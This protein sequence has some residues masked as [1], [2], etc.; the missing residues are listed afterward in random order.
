VIIRSRPTGAAPVDDIKVVITPFRRVARQRD[1]VFRGIRAA[2]QEEAGA[3][4]SLGCRRYRHGDIGGSAKGVG[5]LQKRVLVT[6]LFV[7]VA[8][9]IGVLMGLYTS[10]EL[11]DYLTLGVGMPLG[12]LALD[13][14]NV[15]T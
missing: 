10:A 2:V 15:E 4:A 9:T 3:A 12:L 11:R 13:V 1:V 5:S 8:V 14:N 7:L 6:V